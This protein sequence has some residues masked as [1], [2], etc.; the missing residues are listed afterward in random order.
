MAN[1]I[2]FTEGFYDAVDRLEP[3]HQADVT[4][5]IREFF[6]DQTSPGLNLERMKAN[7]DLW[8]DRKSTRLNSSH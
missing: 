2:A 1:P 4:K 7:P 3:K 5:T 6:R 8:T